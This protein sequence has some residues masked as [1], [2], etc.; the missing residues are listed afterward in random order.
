MDIYKKGTFLGTTETRFS[1]EGVSVSETVYPE[2]LASNWHYHQNPY[3]TLILNGGSIEE[4][5]KR[6]LVCLPA[7]L[8]YYDFDEQ[9]RNTNYRH[10]SRNFNVEFDRLWLC[11]QPL[12]WALRLGP[13]LTG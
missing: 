12:Y 6:S 5:K 8:L 11:K 3:F 10:G 13:G 1:W 7:Q 4:R 2:G 9:H